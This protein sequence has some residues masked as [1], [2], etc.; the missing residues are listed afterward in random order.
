MTGPDGLRLTP[1]PGAR[2]AVIGAAGGIGRATVTA[3]ANAGCRVF[4]LDRSD[5]LS[6]MSNKWPD[7]VIPIALDATD[8]ASVDAA[9]SQISAEV[10]GL[11]GLVHLAGFANP[12][13]PV[14]ETDLADW[15]EVVE[16]NLDSGFLCVRAAIPLLRASPASSVVL[17]AS[18]L[19]VK[20][21]PGYGPYAAAKAGLLAFMR[22]LAAE[23]APQVRVNAVAPS[24]VET[25][26]L[27]GGTGRAERSLGF[28]RDA[29]VQSVPLGRMAIAE[30][31][32]GP[33]V[34][35]LGPASGY[36]TGQTLH[37]NG[38][39]VMS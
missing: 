26:F 1:A 16:G 4:A 17:A 32:V 22:V 35:L 37:V 31:I 5:P 34:F 12:R 25:P 23:L 27:T 33:I 14:A 30:D 11:D 24:A 28:D 8:P 18:G 15:R 20:P 19:A 2:I 39:L 29:Y 13:A 21:A 3:L 7:A 36:L 9:F 38:G 10:S 6:T